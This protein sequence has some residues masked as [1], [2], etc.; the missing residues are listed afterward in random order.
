MRDRIHPLLAST[1]LPGSNESA[2]GT[3]ETWR[4]SNVDPKSPPWGDQGLIW[5]LWK[6]FP[7][8]CVKAIRLHRLQ[9]SD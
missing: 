3:D 2:L 6:R 5:A 7:Q 8:R 4:A 9:Y 1:L